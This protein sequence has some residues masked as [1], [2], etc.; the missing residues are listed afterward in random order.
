MSEPVKHHYVP[1]IYLKRFSL[2]LNGD[3]YTL[4]TNS[5]YPANVKLTNKNKICYGLKRYTF[6]DQEVMDMYKIEDPNII[7]K[8]CF[9]YENN[10]LEYL[11]DKIDYNK[12]LTKSEFEKLVRIIVNVKLRNPVF[13]DSYSKFDPKSTRVQKETKKIR[14]EA[15]QFCKILGLDTDLVNKA[16]EMVYEKF[17]DENYLLNVYRAGIYGDEEVRE[18]LIRKLKNWE[19]IVLNT[20]YENPFITSDN[21]GFNLNENNHIF[22]ADFDFVNALVFPIS[23]KSILVLKRS[24][25]QDLEIFKKIQY[26]RMNIQGVLS[27]NKATSQNANKIIISNSKEQLIITKES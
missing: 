22:N 19:M 5:S 14:N 24:E 23:P 12:K 18:E 21:P 2:N 9:S 17:K 15:T 20:D 6:D 26:R 4:K 27:I 16:V 11:F 10:D 8:S 7:E 3:L 1:Q 25:N 13:S